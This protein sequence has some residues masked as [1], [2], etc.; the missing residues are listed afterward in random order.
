MPASLI[1]PVVVPALAKK[2]WKIRLR[3][4]ADQTAWTECEDFAELTQA[5]GQARQMSPDA[6]LYITAPS[7]A[8]LD[9]E[10]RVSAGMIMFDASDP[11]WLGP[12]LGDVFFGGLR[13]LDH[14]YAR[15]KGARISVEASQAA[16]NA[17]LCVL[18]R[19]GLLEPPRPLRVIGPPALPK[20]RKARKD[21][22]KPRKPRETAAAKMRR[23]WEHG[24]RRLLLNRVKD[25]SG[26][27]DAW[28]SYGPTDWDNF[29]PVKPRKR[30]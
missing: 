3:V 28:L 5:V 8:A 22:D 17:A 18:K 29:A 14:L 7:E 9:H 1:I 21:K 25:E 19:M 2:R 23:L 26:P 10:L 11:A 6:E 12:P 16:E 24:R 27:R 30:R 20:P 15:L 13:N 4:D